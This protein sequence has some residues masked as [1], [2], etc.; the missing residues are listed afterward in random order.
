MLKCGVCLWCFRSFALAKS[1]VVLTTKTLGGRA[2]EAVTW[3]SFCSVLVVKESIQEE[4][5]GV[6]KMV[7]GRKMFVES[8]GG[9][10]LGRVCFVAHKAYESLLRKQSSES[11]TLLRRA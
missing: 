10:S 2:P 6:R 9:M 4:V 11:V 7:D 1:G 8:L 5:D 3:L